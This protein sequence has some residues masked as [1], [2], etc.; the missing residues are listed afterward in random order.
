MGALPGI[1]IR[2][3]GIATVGLAFTMFA[4]GTTQAS[5][6][7]VARRP[8]FVAPATASGNFLLR[9]G[10]FTPLPDMPGT[11][12]TSH[13]RVNN[14]GQ[15][16]GAALA[17]DEAAPTVYGFVQRD[18]VFS[19]IEVRG[20]STTIPFGI[21]DRGDVAGVYI[22]AGGAVRGFVRDEDGD[23]TKINIP[24]TSEV[25][26]YDINNRGEV[27]GYYVDS[28]DVQHG[29]RWARGRI[30]TVDPPE[31]AAEPDGP[32]T[33]VQ[34]INDLGDVVGS[35]F[36]GEVTHAFIL[37]RGRYTDIDPPPGLFAEAGDVNNRGQ[38]VGRYGVLVDEATAKLRGFRWE[39]GNL[40]DIPAAP[41][42]RC[43][44]VA[45]GINERGQ[46]VVPAPG[47]I[48]PGCPIALADT[49]NLP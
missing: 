8:E 5:A 13:V 12:E 24:G 38:V 49:V 2:R 1:R 7:E 33:R 46:I 6:G 40:T 21:N 31:V 22:D 43:D 34:G 42:D 14:R 26:V 48:K 41:G 44:T 25:A 30:T 11:F 10:V 19:R 37:R 20:A 9:G 36:D 45:S 47:S 32:G 39:R 35:Y 29:Y 28:G 15:S 23:V 16:V 27:V 4:V 17:G 18:G 3:R